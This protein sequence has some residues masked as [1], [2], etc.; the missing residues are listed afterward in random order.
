M[1]KQ[2]ALFHAAADILV[3]PKFFTKAV[4]KNVIKFLKVHS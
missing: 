4:L 2:S 1:K 3:S